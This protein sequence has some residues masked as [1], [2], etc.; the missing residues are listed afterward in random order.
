MLSL[1]VFLPLLFA[2][3]IVLIAR[4]DALVSRY[5][6]L[7]G[8]LLTAA[9]A[10]V[11]VLR[12][13]FAGSGFQL[14]ERATWLPQIGASYHLGIDGLSLLL[15]ILT[16]A[17]TPVAILMASAD[18]L[19]DRVPLYM[20]LILLLETSLL[21]LFVSLDLVMFYIFW[22]AVLIPAYL[23]IGVWGGERRIY[24]AI[25]YVVY[26]M[27]GS[28]LMLVGV[29]GVYV[30]STAHS[31][32]IPALLAAPV[33]PSL[34]MAL[35]LA[36]GLAFAIKSALWPFHS[37]VPDVYTESNVPTTIMLAGVVSKMGAYGFLRLALPLFPSA[38]HTL[39]GVASAL[40][41]V[42]IL[43][44]ALLALTQT[45]ARR[46]VA[47]SSISHMG[48]ILLGIFALNM[49]GVQGATLQMVNH[50]ITTAAL[51]AI[52]AMIAA[53]WGT[54]DLRR[55]GG[56]GSRALVLTAIFM[57]VTLSALGLPGLNSFPAE[58]LI[59]LGAYRTSGVYGVLGTLGVILAAWYMLRLFKHSMHGPEMEGAA[60]PALGLQLRINELSALLPLVVLIVW[61]GVVPGGWLQPA[62]SAARAIIGAV[63]GAQ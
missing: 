45:D 46:L 20:A 7:G 27:A 5:T 32:D 44:G 4:T 62:A 48:F 51:F 8:A 43:Y 50:G 35:L 52:V 47:C 13:D 38:A 9:L 40:A 2:V 41:V 55:L 60:T 29:V 25:K 53:R 3:A 23:M 49:Q 12:F 15:V 61:I 42:G 21:G 14:Q 24:A 63:S 39:Q 10:V 36:F 54:T 34:Q 22:E 18:N 16:V 30:Y 19:S 58:F 17:V 26:T 28:L 57:L 33:A 1:L 6:A 37:W 11:I 31:F 59:L 56:L